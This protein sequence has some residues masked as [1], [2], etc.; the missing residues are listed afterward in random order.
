V[1]A[2]LLKFS[3]FW[4][5]ASGHYKLLLQGLPGAGGDFTGVSQQPMR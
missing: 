3:D 5:F 2:D 4:E 1:H